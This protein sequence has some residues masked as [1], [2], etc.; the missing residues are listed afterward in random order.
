MNKL[1]L[2]LRFYGRCLPAVM[3]TAMKI[4]FFRLIH[5]PFRNFRIRKASDKHL[6]APIDINDSAFTTLDLFNKATKDYNVF[7]IGEEHAIARNYDI[8]L[9]LL[10]NFVEKYDL[11]CILYEAGFA[12]SQFVNRFLKT[13]DTSILNKMFEKYRGTEG[14]TKEHYEHLLRIYEYNRTLPEDKKLFFAGIDIQHQ[15]ITGV[16]YILSLLPDKEPSE[17]IRGAIE[18]L[19]KLKN[20]NISD[21]TRDTLKTAIFSVFD[22]MN[23]NEEGFC[24]FFGN[25]Y[26]EFK[27]A[28]EG[29]IQ[30]YD[31]YS[32][33]FLTGEF[34]KKREEYIYKNFVSIYNHHKHD[35]YWGAWGSAHTRLVGAGL[36]NGKTISQYLNND[37]EP[38]K[39]KVM[40]VESM[41]YNCYS[42]NPKKDYRS[43]I[44]PWNGKTARAATASDSDYLLYKGSKRAQYHLLIK[45]SPPLTNM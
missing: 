4:L 24:N 1:I 30:S 34:H 42:L 8:Q 37:F 29:I 11:K 7:F 31:C 17:S 21:W 18:K 40:C 23:D 43:Y 28:C 3:E 41:Y 35:I 10:K 6:H 19:I 14:Y 32:N 39:G 45:N 15:K 25:E 16:H 36:L 20:T 5:W 2:A 26:F 13:G 22:G 27:L 38:T 44:V 33:G 9:Y 12:D